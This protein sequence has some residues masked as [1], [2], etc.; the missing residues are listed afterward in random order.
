MS[1]TVGNRHKLAAIMAADAAGYSRLMVLDEGGTIAALDAARAA[2]RWQVDSFHGRV[3]DTAGDSV[4]ALFETASG[5]VNAA[6][7]VQAQL[8]ASLEGV[9]ADRRMRFRIGVHLGDVIEKSDGSVYGDGVNIAARLQGLAPHGGILVSDAVHGAVR[10]RIH[11][12]FEDLGEQQVKNIV[13][14]VR[15]Y[16]V[17]VA[18]THGASQ[19]VSEPLQSSR[20]RP[21]RHLPRQRWWALGALLAFL[22]GLCT[23]IVVRNIGSTTADGPPLMS[24]GVLPFKSTNDAPDVAFADSFTRELTAA[25]GRGALGWGTSVVSTTAVADYRGQQTDARALG[26]KLGVRYLVEGEVRRDDDDVVSSL[27]LIDAQTARQVWSARIVTPLSKAREWP[28]LPVLRAANQ[29]WAALYSTETQRVIAN[30]VHNADPVELL[31]RFMIAI[32]SV[33]TKEG[34]S[35]ARDLCEQVVRLGPALTGAAYCQAGLIM[36][37]VELDPGIVSAQL[38]QRI[39]GLTRR[40]VQQAPSE[41][42]AWSLRSGAL[43][44]QNQREAFDDAIAE[45]IRLDPSSA[46]YRTARAENMIYLGRAEMAFPLLAR[47]AELNT[48]AESRYY[49][50]ITCHALLSLGRYDDAVG[51]CEKTT[52]GAPSY[53]LYANLA[54]IYAQKGDLAKAAAAKNKTL[55][56]RPE[57]TITWFKA[58]VQRTSNN[59]VYQGQVD[60]HFLPGLRK[61]GFAEK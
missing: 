5:A 21:L 55:E 41:S 28:E 10:H 32:Q 20:L 22:A 6:L 4:L 50:H 49:E 25:V 47:A 48:G 15:A 13:D 40:A 1:E 35:K 8:E 52:S 53:W 26:Q 54:A 17:E 29:L 33:E 11:A 27:F 45:A 2:F 44:L 39:D 24:L 3:V 31:F 37:E 14:P 42:S 9:P 34:L 46:N 38:L 43:E 19:S 12:K 57:F 59:P 60:A 36:T 23:Y 16:R 58:W 51:H 30:E 7:A 18:T 61:A 56:L